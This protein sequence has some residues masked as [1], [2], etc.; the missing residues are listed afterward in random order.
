MAFREET[1]ADEAGA[2]GIFDEPMKK[3]RK[4]VY[5]NNIGMRT[6]LRKTRAKVSS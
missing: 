6:L 1:S 5:Y 3:R 2:E 4:G